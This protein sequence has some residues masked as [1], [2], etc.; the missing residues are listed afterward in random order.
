[1][2]LWERL[3]LELDV[4]DKKTMQRSEHQDIEKLPLQN[5]NQR[6]RSEPDLHRPL[7][8]T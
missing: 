4:M 5:S 8:D 1:M 6:R 3:A 7:R 2:K